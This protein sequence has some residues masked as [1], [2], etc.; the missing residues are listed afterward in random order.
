VKSTPVVSEPGVSRHRLRGLAIPYLQALARVFLWRKKPLVIAIA[1]NRGK[2]VMKRLFGELLGARYRVRT[3]PRSYNTE[4]GLPLAV[5]NLEI[6]THSLWNVLRT[7]AQAAWTAFCSNEKL[8]VLV[9]ELGVRQAGDMRQL[10]QTVRPDITVLTTLTPS[11]STDVDVLRTLQDEVKDLCQ[12]VGARCH[13]LV[14]DEDLL[15]REVVKTLPVPPVSLGLARWATN[16]QGLT[17]QSNG[18]LY[19][20]TRELIGDSERVSVQAAVL[21]AERWTKLTQGE[22][23]R[24]LAGETDLGERQTGV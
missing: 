4:I 21:L 22:I 19:H 2:T 24:F 16:G 10:L 3:N 8:E 15:L 9:L 20:V 23:S 1:G 14:E 13:F 5:L 6:D 12:A 7:L 18:H 17:L 11:Y